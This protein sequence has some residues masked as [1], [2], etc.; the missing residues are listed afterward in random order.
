MMFLKR[1]FVLTLLISSGL[2]VYATP[3]RDTYPKNPGI[4]VINYFFKIALS[5]DTDEIVGEATIDV[6]FLT[7]G[8]RELRLDLTNTSK[9]LAGKGMTVQRVTSGGNEIEY[10]HID[11][12]ISIKLPTAAKANPRGRYTIFYKGVPATGLKIANNK[13]GE[14]TFFSDNWL[15]KGGIGCRRL[16]ILRIKPRA[17]FW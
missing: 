12:A 7:S 1:Y 8:T 13:Y 17:N 16:T 15:T 4:D 2:T 9:E 6:N 5:D 3:H 10:S 14:R 11:N